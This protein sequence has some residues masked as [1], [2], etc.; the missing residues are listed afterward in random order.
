MITKK[1]VEHIAKLANLDISEEE[2][3]RYGAQLGAVVEYINELNQVDTKNIEPTSQTTG[4]VNMTRIDVE[5]IE[6][7]L[8][9]NDALSQAHHKIDN[10]FSVDMLLKEKDLS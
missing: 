2:V 4:L 6:R 3:R 10:Y 9:S 5:N 8:P 1:Q 7:I